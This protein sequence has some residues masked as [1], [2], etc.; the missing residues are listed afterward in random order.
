MLLLGVCNA[1]DSGACLVRDGEIV[2]AANEERFVRKKNISTF[3]QESI[4]Y[5]LSSQGVSI[6]DIDWVGCGAWCGIDSNTTLYRLFED[7]VDQIDHAQS[8]TKEHL[9]D[10]IRVTI[11]RDSDQKQNLLQGLQSMGVSPEKVIFCDHHYSHAITAFYCSPFEEAYV[12]TADGRGDFR[13]VS[14]WHGTRSGGMKLIDF[15][16]ELTSPGAM[17]GFITNLLGFIPDRHEGKVTGLSARGR[18]TEV[19]QIL[20]SGFWFDQKIGKIRSRIGDFY[21]PSLSAKMPKLAEKLSAFSREDIAFAAQKLLEEILTGFLMKYIKSNPARSVNLC[22]AGGCMSNVKLNYEISELS[23]V[24]NIYVFP[25]MGDGG[26]ALGGAIHAELTKGEKRYFALPTV[27]L[28]PE[29][30]ELEIL[31]VL[32]AQSLPF[33]KVSSAEK[34][35]RT[36]EWLMQGKIVGWFQGRMEYGP[37]ALGARSILASAQNTGITQILN[38]CLHRSDFMPFAPVTIREYAST[39]FVGW[40]EDQTASRF[41]TTCYKCTPYMMEKCPAVVHVDNTARPQVVFREDNPEYYEVVKSYIERTGFPALINTSFNHH[42][43]PIVN[44]PSDAV[45]SLLKGNV[46]VLIAGNFMVS[47]LSGKGSIQVGESAVSV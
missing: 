11:S 32:E 27:Y 18:L 3:P 14:L 42:E 40:N 17:Y 31:Q 9:L 4:R 21:R 22:L 47:A 35:D 29:Y 43:E 2:A 24:K 39:C 37:R 7:V 12:F 1:N 13:S 6:R 28:G 45:R 5:V 38:R 10:R 25:Q 23:P 19:F 8:D 26:N 46:D 20:K 34:V 15:A 30:Q 44:N 16:T 41:M 36:V 33:V